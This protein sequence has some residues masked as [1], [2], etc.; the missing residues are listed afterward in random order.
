[1]KVNTP[2]KVL[3]VENG[4]HKGKD[5]RS[6]PNSPLNTF[7]LGLIWKSRVLSL[8]SKSKV[9]GSTCLPRFPGSTPILLYPTP[10]YR[11]RVR[12]RE[13]LPSPDLFQKAFRLGQETG[14]LG[15]DRVTGLCEDAGGE[16]SLSLSPELP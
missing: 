4:L 12:F 14:F 8:Q 9:G 15:V 10:I 13:L 2:S 5:E 16:S 1:M 3:G 11:L 6:L 7:V